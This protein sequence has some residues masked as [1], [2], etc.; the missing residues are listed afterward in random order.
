[1]DTAG[2]LSNNTPKKPLSANIRENPRPSAARFFCRVRRFDI[3]RSVSMMVGVDPMADSASRTQVI[4]HTAQ[5]ATVFDGAVTREIIGAFFRVHNELGY[6]YVEAV[7]RRALAVE[8]GSRGLRVV[9]EAPMSVVY[10]GVE[11]GT[12]RADLVVDGRVVVEVK[13]SPAMQPA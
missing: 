6:G 5:T 9:C 1:A 3:V 8:I 12:F 10:R 4:M 11:V 13:S 7:Y 2:R